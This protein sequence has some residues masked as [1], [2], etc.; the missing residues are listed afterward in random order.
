MKENAYTHLL[1]IAKAY[2]DK[3]QNQD[4]EIALTSAEARVE[5]FAHLKPYQQDEAIALF[6]AYLL[7]KQKESQ[8]AFSG[9]QS[10]RE[11]DLSVS[12]F[13]QGQGNA[14]SD[15]FLAHYRK[16]TGRFKQVLICRG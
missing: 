8:L 15:S 2:V 9:V 16:L 4:V 5:E 13:D 3:A 12:Y 14:P 7:A 6:A 1:F 10:E 11:G